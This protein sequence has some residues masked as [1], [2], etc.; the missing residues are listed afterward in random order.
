VR[1]FYQLVSFF[2]LMV[3]A[4]GAFLLNCALILVSLDCQMRSN[5]YSILN[6]IMKN[7]KHLISSRAIGLGCLLVGASS[8][9]NAALVAY[10]D[11]DYAGSTNLTLSNDNNGTGW[12]AAWAT[13]GVSGLTTSGSGKSLY[14]DQ[15]SNGLETDGSTHVWT[16]S[17]K[18]NERDFTG[19][20]S[21]NSEVLYFT[22]LVRGYSSATSGGATE[23]DLR[24]T[25]HT[26]TG[27]SGSMRANVGITDGTLFAAAATD[28]YGS[29]DTEANAFLDDT[30]Y[31]L[32]MRRD[33]SS[34]RASLI[35]A[36]GD[37]SSFASQPGT[38][39]VNQAGAT[40]AGLTSIRF[41]TNGDGDGGLRVDEM[42]IATDWDSAVNG[43]ILVPEPSSYALLAGLLALT[44]VMIRRRK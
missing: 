1:F 14:F 37:A 36:D 44:S 35:A 13:T 6:N 4:R 28:G 11:F 32:A 23:A 12:D 42:R 24:F 33:S 29:G 17:S 19:T 40:G 5:P 39:Q 21:L 22:A 15:G 27:A 34:I 41:V 20:V 10:E 2:N 3:N 7:K 18:G 26:G 25:F 16:E 38:W 9:A 30:T 8:A 43:L 31:L